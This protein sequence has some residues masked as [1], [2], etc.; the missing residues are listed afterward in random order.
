MCIRDSPPGERPTEGAHASLPPA[1]S[2]VAPGF[3]TPISV[4][5]S[6]RL[7]EVTPGG[8]E[9]GIETPDFSR[10]PTTF[11]DCEVDHAATEESAPT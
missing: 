9:T 5:S 8:Y 10:E 6:P 11:L 3:A 2:P 4:A 7:R 1:A